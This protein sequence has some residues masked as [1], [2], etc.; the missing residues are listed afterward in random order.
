MKN[1]VPRSFHLL[2][3]NINSNDFKIKNRKKGKICKMEDF[4]INLMK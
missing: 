4:E 3:E 1:R 2:V